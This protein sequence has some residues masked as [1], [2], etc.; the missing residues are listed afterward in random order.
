[1]HGLEFGRETV[2]HTS[3]HDVTGAAVLDRDDIF[4]QCARRDPAETIDQDLL[5]VRCRAAGR[6]SEAQHRIATRRSGIEMIAIR[7]QRECRN[8][9]KAEHFAAGQRCRVTVVDPVDEVQRAGVRIDRE[10]HDRLGCRAGDIQHTGRIVE[11]QAGC[12]GQAAG[13]GG[14]ILL[15]VDESQCASR[16]GSGETRQGS[17]FG[18]QHVDEGSVG[19]DR[20][21]AHAA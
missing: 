11:Q 3:L 6:K 12:T 13:A 14:A 2:D 16:R 18:T 19:T 20:H 7:G 8:P 10:A 17:G 4:D 9:F 5:E 15:E 21:V 1:M